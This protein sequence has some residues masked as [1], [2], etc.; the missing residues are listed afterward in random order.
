MSKHAQPLVFIDVE[1][2]GLNY[3]RGSIIE[4][5]ALRYENGKI[6]D[7]L[8]TF[9][10]PGGAI[11]YNITILTGITT[12]D[13]ESAPSFADIADD[14]LALCEGAIMVAHNVR[15]DYSF[16]RQEFKRLGKSFKP[17]L[18]C[19]VKLSKY[20]YPMQRRHRLHDIIHHHGLTFEHRHRANDD[21]HVLVQLWEKLLSTFSS[22]Q[23]ESALAAQIQAPSIPRHLN[24][25]EMR[26]LPTGAGVYMFNDEKGMPVYIGKS[27]NIKKRVLS[28]F[29]RDTTEYKEF[30]ISQ[31]VRSV[32]FQQTAGELSALLLESFL[33]KEHMPLYNKRLR[34]LRK[35]SVIVKGDQNGY[36]TTEVSEL[37][38]EDVQPKQHI[39]AMYPKRSRAKLFVQ[40]RVKTFQ[41]CPK[42][43]N[44]EKSS[45][46]C[47]SYQLGACKGACIGK[48]P[49]KAYNLR[50]HI[51]FSHHSSSV[52]EWPHDGPVIITERDDTQG[53]SIGYIVDN[54][55]IKE[56]ITA[57]DEFEP[58]RRPLKS[59]FDLDAYLI[60]RSYLLRHPEKVSIL[61]YAI[62]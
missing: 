8:T 36:N 45:G 19:T 12:E 27:I 53:L 51:A 32:T 1:T 39:L 13:V 44:L 47:F 43:C 37:A 52:Q 46:A 11:P 2:N 35:L 22:E 25:A 9:L 62:R 49:R 42:L 16:V 7:S 34:R 15:F 57:Y 58:D 6:V 31:A 4:I 17:K 20:F 30:K 59:V 3:S 40:D 33:I 26:A 10:N 38:M 23:I 50:F 56:T 24:P 55:I 54:W 14:L 41:L 61:P 28:H 5:A 48:E 60:L 18:L 21:A 29:T